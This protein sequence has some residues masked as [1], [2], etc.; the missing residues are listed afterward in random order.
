M[1]ETKD[2]FL[3]RV[4]KSLSWSFAGG[5]GRYGMPH[6]RDY[7]ITPRGIDGA[8]L[9]A[10]VSSHDYDASGVRLTRLP[11]EHGVAKVL[12]RGLASASEAL[13]DAARGADAKYFQGQAAPKRGG[14][15]ADAELVEE[16]IRAIHTEEGR[17]AGTP[18]PAPA[19]VARFR[20]FWAETQ[21]LLPPELFSSKDGVIRARWMDGHERTLWINFP[22]KGPLGFSTSVP[23]AGGYGLRKMNARCIDDQ[24]IV[25]T[26]LAIGV[27]CTR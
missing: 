8:A 5:N 25:P 24:D 15:A 11:N 27:R 7:S 17:E 2:Y 16:R 18:P 19:S 22:E 4:G 21:G 9:I 1:S 6:R 12:L 13:E 14:A 26:V 23:R 3:R 20:R 10:H